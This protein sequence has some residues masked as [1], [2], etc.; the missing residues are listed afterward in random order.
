MQ[1][2]YSVFV[3]KT[4]LGFKSSFENICDYLYHSYLILVIKQFYII[5][6]GNYVQNWLKDFETKLPIGNEGGIHGDV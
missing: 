6:A 1:Q 4:I 3:L 5:I 2:A